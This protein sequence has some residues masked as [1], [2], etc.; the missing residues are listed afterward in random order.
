[1]FGYNE[2]ALIK[3][4]KINMTIDKLFEK[5]RI[6]I[7]AIKAKDIIREQYEHLESFLKK[8][9]INI[10]HSFT[11][12]SRNPQFK[13]LISET[14]FFDDKFVYDIVVGVDNI[15]SHIVKINQVSK[16]GTAIVP[17]YINEKNE[18][19][20]TKQRVEFNSRLIISYQEQSQFSYQ[21][22]TEKFDELLL[23]AEIL[24]KTI[25]E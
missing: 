6:N 23:V 19:G 22:T 24:T 1:L 3:K 7:N 8:R 21:A 9:N 14:L 18:D 2:L 4:M 10:V 17:N 11:Q 25:S 5:I 20:T 13:G 15:D 12:I 16:V